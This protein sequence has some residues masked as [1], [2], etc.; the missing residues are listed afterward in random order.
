[1]ITLT[2]KRR[3][4]GAAAALATALALVL[5]AGAPARAHVTVA[6]ANATAGAYTVLTFSVPHGCD[7]AATTAIAIQ[8]PEPINSVTPTVN[9]SWE[10]ETVYT[11]LAE[12]VADAHGNELTER[13]DQVVYTALTP[14]PDGLRDTFEL[15]LRL[16]EETAGSTLA[17]PVV[18]TCGDAEHPWIQVPEAGQDA[19]ALDSPAPL[20]EVAAAEVEDD[21]AEPA[22]AEDDTGG[23]AL[24]YVALAIG[25]LGLLLGGLSFWRARRQP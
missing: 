5:A 1:V 9:P 7:G 22:E 15:S 11:E 3:L 13:A 10:V 2:S 6:A 21:G 17:F 16:P 8:I 12:P 24:P 14:L 19:D 23:D 20:V 18:Q 4:A 25:M